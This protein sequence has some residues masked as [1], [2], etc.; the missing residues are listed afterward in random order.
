MNIVIDSWMAL[1]YYRISLIHRHRKLQITIFH[2]QF[3]NEFP[4]IRETKEK[5]HFL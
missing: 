3:K 2:F 5:S 4:W 1:N